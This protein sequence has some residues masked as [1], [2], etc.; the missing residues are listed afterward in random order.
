VTGFILP[1]LILIN[2]RIKTFPKA[3]IVICSVVI[4]SIWLEHY[5]LL[6]PI[7]SPDAVRLPAVIAALSPLRTSLPTNS[8]DAIR[9]PFQIADGLIGLGFLGL[10]A[11]SVAFFLNLFPEVLNP[12]PSEV[13]R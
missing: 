12:Q 7:Y 2:K 10:M 11:A 6:G 4:V 8:L 1:F 13:H 3:M 5:L 9:L